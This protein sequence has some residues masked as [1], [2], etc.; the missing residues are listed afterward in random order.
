[1]RR[2][3][4]AIAMTGLA[5]VLAGCAPLGTREWEEVNHSPNTSLQLSTLGIAAKVD[6]LKRTD[7]RQAAAEY[8][9][10]DLM[11]DTAANMAGRERDG[12]NPGNNDSGSL[13]AKAEPWGFFDDYEDPE[14]QI[15]SQSD[16]LAYA[17]KNGGIKYGMGKTYVSAARIY[18][19]KGDLL[20]AFYG[21]EFTPNEK[22]YRIRCKIQIDLSRI[23]LVD[24]VN[25]DNVAR[26]Y[27]KVAF[28]DVKNKSDIHH[29]MHEG[30]KFT[31]LNVKV[32]KGSDWW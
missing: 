29:V 10:G 26:I 9:A 27:I 3:G 21:E 24:I 17:V 5:A 7:P 2:T 4:K 25:S 6:S 23:G 19:S 14:I 8:H 12:S 11:T 22:D 16:K 30:S 18:N 32:P 31:P 13:E 28:V 20:Q 15:D 1:M